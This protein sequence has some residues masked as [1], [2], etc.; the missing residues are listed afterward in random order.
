MS[1]LAQTRGWPNR[2]DWAEEVGRAVA[3]SGSW[4]RGRRAYSEALRVRSCSARLRKLIGRE[5]YIYSTTDLVY[6]GRSL[7]RLV[8][9][10]EPVVWDFWAPQIAL[11]ADFSERPEDE[12]EVRR[13]WCS[14]HGIIYAYL[15]RDDDAL[16]SQVATLVARRLAEL[17]GAQ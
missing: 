13:Q 16:W 8:R 5:P 2:G 14:T 11:A 15:P 9:D 1:A 12:V 17:E 6:V 4:S 3:A 7:G 10:G